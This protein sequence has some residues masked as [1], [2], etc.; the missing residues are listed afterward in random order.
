MSVSG[1]SSYQG[2][3][4]NKSE[5]ELAEMEQL[6]DSAHEL[7]LNGQYDSAKKILQG[8][9]AEK[10]VSRPLYQ[11]EMISLML[12]MGED[13]AALE[14]MQSLHEDLELMFDKEL[15]EKALSV[16]HGE[17]NKVYKGDSYERSAFYALMALSYIKQQNY[18][19]ALRCVKNG[20]LADADSNSEQSINDNALLYYIG[21][22]AASKVKNEDDAAEYMRGFYSAMEVRGFRKENQN[23]DPAANDC[24]KQLQKCDPNVVL[25]LWSGQ[26]P[27]VACT[28]EYKENRSIIR[29]VNY[30]DSL[31]ISVGMNNF[32]YMPHNVGDIN[33]QAT[34]RGGRLMDN[35]LADK[36]AAKK[37]M[38][39][40]GNLFFIAGS[41]LIIAANY[42]PSPTNICFLC[43][44]VGCYIV[45]GV[46]YLVGAAITPTADGRYWRNLPCQFYV[47]P[48]K[49]PPG[50]H[51]IAITG[52]RNSDV[53]GL[54][55]Y[56]L[57]VPQNGGMNVVHLPMLNTGIN[58]A[59]IVRQKFEEERSAALKKAEA[60]RFAKELK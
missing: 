57:T 3:F 36:A 30:F 16:W 38:E 32:N 14:L 26:G 49:L 55:M 6:N 8:L 28:G 22:L 48:L 11:M 47:I 12:L 17:V 1:C 59:E 44:G 33:W 19:D 31:A 2:D 54:A 56:N 50:E 5:D 52:M 9:T 40:T 29:S 34:T 41:G 18:E 35:V 60:N 21:F 25:V 53:A 20:L 7:L 27:T 43:S 51:Q 15:E 13:K 46:V 4:V 23:G 58:A 24:F 42:A 45:G 37:A 10:T 39:A